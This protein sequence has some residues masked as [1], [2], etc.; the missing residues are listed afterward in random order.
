MGIIKKGILGGFSGKV[1][2]VVGSSWKGIAY[3]RSLPTKFKDPRSEL[4]LIQR[5]KFAVTITF[6]QPMTELLRT[7]WKFYSNRKSPFNAAMAYTIAKAVTGAYP[8]YSINPAKVLISRGSLASPVNAAA[9][10]A[11]GAINFQWDDNS[12]SASARQTDKALLAV[13]NPA[14]GDAVL[15]TAGAARSD[16]AQSVTIPADWS[17]DSVEAYL[18]FISQDGREIANSVYL[19][20]LTAA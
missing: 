7:G 11:S 16:T 14:K 17:G 19:G 3:M 18:G 4:Q 12:G 15:F 2:N 13:L 6:L 9:T 20:S 10:A 1:G 8:D 5:S